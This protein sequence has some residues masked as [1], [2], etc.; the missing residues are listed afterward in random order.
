MKQS[1]MGDIMISTLN[2][3]PKVTL[4]EYAKILMTISKAIS[5]LVL[6]DAILDSILNYRI[7]P[8]M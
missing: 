3:L 6:R 1:D 5:Y 7:K 2:S 4:F 8:A